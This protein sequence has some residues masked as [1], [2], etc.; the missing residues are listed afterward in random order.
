M[1]DGQGLI[2]SIGGK[3]RSKEVEKIDQGWSSSLHFIRCKNKGED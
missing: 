1:T 3:E 2:V